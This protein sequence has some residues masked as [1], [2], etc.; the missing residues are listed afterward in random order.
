MSR[1]HLEAATFVFCVVLVVPLVTAI[2]RVEGPQAIHAPPI[3]VRVRAER[4]APRSDR[5][6]LVTRPAP[7]PAAAPHAPAP[8]PSPT[9]PAATAEPVHTANVVERR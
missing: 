8:K 2:V 4:G 5:G 9:P 3:E 1:R 6:R 7:L